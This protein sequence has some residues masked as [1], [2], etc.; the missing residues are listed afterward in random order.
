MG[1]IRKVVAA[2]LVWATSA[3]MLMAATPFVVCR[4]PTGELK[5]F[6]SPSNATKSPCCK[7]TCCT[8]PDGTSSCCSHT[9][10]PDSV[11]IQETD[12]KN[13]SGSPIIVEAN[14][15]KTLVQAQLTAV[16]QHESKV[17]PLSTQSLHLQGES[18]CGMPL[19]SSVPGLLRQELDASPPPTDLITSLQRLVI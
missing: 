14:C 19:V 17:T 9:N 15:Q 16:C 8:S 3:S 6:C 10:L 1:R 12:S 5:P 2:S 7:G 4:C 18:Q 13:S 11:R